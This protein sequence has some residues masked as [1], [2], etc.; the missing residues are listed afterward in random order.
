V[1]DQVRDIVPRP[2]ASLGHVP[3]SVP[4]RSHDVPAVPIRFQ[5]ASNENPFPPLESVIAAVADSAMTLN[6]YPDMANHELREGIA[7]ELGVC[8]SQVVPSTGSVAAL[9]HLLSAYCEPGDEV[10]HAWRS[11]EAYP[12]AAAVAG[13]QAV[14]VPVFGSGVHDH[15]SMLAA[16]TARTKV[17]LLC[18]PNNPTGPAL[19]HTDVA[20]FVLQ[21]PASVVVALDEAY[22][23][24]VRMED[25]LRALELVA[26]HRNV[27]VMR[28]LSKA[29]GL[30]GL[31]VGYLVAND[32]MA[33]AVRA[34]ALPFGVSSVAQ[35]A[36]LA[37]LAAKS[38]LEV[39]VEMIVRERD[40]LAA[41]LRSQGWSVPDTQG[42]FVWLKL[43]PGTAQFAER[44]TE[45][46]I[47]LCPFANEGVRITIGE[48]AANDAVVRLASAWLTSIST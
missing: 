12:I 46:G 41:T 27:V 42:N 35:A 28:T 44:A 11:F 18:S 4:G 2:R 6:R 45:A 25:P 19:T 20:D 7:D 32:E 29:A 36:A 8:A 9:F 37:S 15:G 40:R 23:E 3:P 14:P 24:F 30:A 38:E 13:A 10:V 43:G 1:R 16:I 26:A 21:V 47:S 22:Y 48:P 34:C 5:L 39:R 17:V 31:R 33:A